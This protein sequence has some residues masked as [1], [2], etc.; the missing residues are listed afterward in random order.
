MVVMFSIIYI[1]SSIIIIYILSSII[2][3]YIFLSFENEGRKCDSGVLPS[4]TIKRKVGSHAVSLDRGAYQLG[5]LVPINC[6]RNQRTI[7]FKSQAL[8]CRIRSTFYREHDWNC[9]QITQT[10]I[11]HNL[12]HRKPLIQSLIKTRPSNAFKYLFK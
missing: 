1:L 7:H 10:S 12:H 8:C 2:Y 6:G 9:Q 4:L 5:L 3:D 11:A